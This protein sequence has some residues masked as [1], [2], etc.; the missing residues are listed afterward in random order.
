MA[1]SS[2]AAHGTLVR[3]MSLP[4]PT[5]RAPHRFLLGAWFAAGLGLVTDVALAQPTLPA[6]PWVGPATPALDSPGAAAA[7]AVLPHLRLPPGFQI[8]P[9]AMVPGARHLAVSPSGTQLVVGSRQD[10][11]W[12]VRERGPADREVRLVAPELSWRLPNGVCWGADGTLFVAEL[13]RVLALPRAESL[14]DD[15]RVSAVAVVPQGQLV[16]PEEATANH[17]ARVCRVDAQGRLYLALGQPYNV[18][19]RGKVALYERLGIGGIIR[20]DGRD[21]SRREVL[22]VGIRNSVGLTLQPGSQTVWFTDNQTDR[23]GDDT[24]PGELNRITQPAPEHFG[25]PW[26]QGRD[27]RIAGSAV[28]PD[29]ADLPPPPRWTRPQAEFPAHQAQ[30]GLS[31]YTGQQFPPEYRG[32]L[33]V[34]AHGSWNRSQ[35]TGALVQFVP[36]RPDGSAGTPQ[37]F[38][39]GWLDPATGRYRGRPVDVAVW[40]DGS[41]LVSDD[42][43]GVVW[44]IHYRQP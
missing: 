14:S 10:R 24:P 7:R 27:V 20:M 13:N 40:R 4:T 42:A 16:P 12:Q 26:F 1:G 21:G 39:E 2:A 19:P 31:F 25:Y 17:G 30:L 33:F 9:F 35:P 38:A 3:E 32:G 41:L 29:L 18:Q 34:A 36:L 43:A 22:A 28:A 44:R 6:V 8:E 37:V 11:V 15:D 23:L 5:A